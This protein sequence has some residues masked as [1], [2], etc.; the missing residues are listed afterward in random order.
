MLVAKLVIGT[1]FRIVVSIVLF[2]TC[3]YFLIDYGADLTH[4]AAAAWY[5]HEP[6]WE[7]APGELRG[8]TVIEVEQRM[9][10][11]Y[12]L[13]Q[14]SGIASNPLFVEGDE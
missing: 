14:Q 5:A 3:L 12:G 7:K 1:C 4:M 8:L 6:G 11:K 9:I 2:G 10:H 13:P